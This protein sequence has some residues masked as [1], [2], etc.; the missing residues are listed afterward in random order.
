MQPTHATEETGAAPKASADDLAGFT[1]SFTTSDG[2]AVEV[3]IARDLDVTITWPTAEPLRF[4]QA[5]WASIVNYAA[6][7]QFARG[8]TRRAAAPAGAQRAFALTVPAAARH[9]EGTEFVSIHAG[10]LKGHV[11]RLAG[12]A[13]AAFGE[14]FADVV[15]PGKEAARL[16]VSVLHAAPAPAPDPPAERT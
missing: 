2:T 4:D 5:T 8:R 11:G 16:R 13:E 15:V 7:L 6:A 14:A 9:L 10:Q 3:T 12:F 1:K